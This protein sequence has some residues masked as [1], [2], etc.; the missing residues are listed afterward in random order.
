MFEVFPGDIEPFGGEDIVEL[1]RRLVYAEAQTSGVPLYNVAVP[2]QITLAD[3]GEDARVEWTGGEASTAYFPHRHVVFQSKATDT[4]PSLWKRETWTKASQRKGKTHILNEALT[5]AL[6]LGASYIGVTATGL[7]GAKPAERREAIREGIRE[8]GGNPDL[9]HSIHIYDGNALADWANRHHAVALWIKEQK[10]GL[11][12]SS[13]ATLNNWGRR[14]EMVSPPYVGGED[15]RF[16]IGSSDQDRLNFDR[17]AA[18]LVAHLQLADGHSARI[19]GPSGLGKSRS[20][21]E[22][23]QTGAAALKDSLLATAVFCDYREVS[24][25]LWDAVNTLADGGA[26]LILVVDECPREEAKKL[27][28][29]ARATG[30]RLRVVTLDTNS[31]SIDVDGCLAI[32]ALASNDQVIKGILASLLPKTTTR[33]EVA[34]IAD[35]CAGYPRIAVLAAQSY[36][37]DAPVFKSVEDVAQRILAGARITDRGQIRALECLSLFDGLAPDARPA[38]FDIVAQTLGLMTGDEMFE[39]LVAAT[40]HG[41]V[42]RYGDVFATQPQPIANYLGAKRLSYLRPS[43]VRAFLQTAPDEQRRSFLGRVR[44][45]CRSSTLRDVAVSMMTW[46]GELA[47]AEQLLTSRGSEFLAAFV[48][49]APDF[50]S[51]LI[52]RTFR[53]ASLADLARVSDDLGGLLDALERLAHRPDTFPAAARNL[54]R[55]SAA[56]A[57][58]GHGRATEITKQLFQLVL[59]GTA[60]PVGVRFA[61]LDEA[62]AEGGPAIHWACTRALD[63]ALET[64][65][66]YGTSGFEQLGDLPPIPDWRPG[67]AAEAIDFHREALGRLAAIRRLSPEAA[68]DAD[69]VVADHLRQLL[70][71]QLFEVVVAYLDEVRAALGFWPEAAKKIGDWLYFDRAQAEPVFAAKVRALYDT[72]LPIDIVDRAVFFSQFWPADIRD[73]DNSYEAGATERDYEF[74]GREAR[75]LAALIARDPVLLTRAIRSMATR[76]LH[77]PFAFADELAKHISTPEAVLGEALAALDQSGTKEGLS[78]VR[79]L[80]RALD[81]SFPEKAEALVQMAKQSE[82]LA[83]RELEI[84]A[85]VGLTEARVWEVADL[86]RSG[87]ASPFQV[88]PLSYGR[89]LDAMAVDVLRALIEA[90]HT[91]STDGGGWAAIEILSMYLYG[92]SSLSREEATLVKAAVLAPL[93]VDDVPDATMSGH[94]FGVLVKLLDLSGY[95]DAAFAGDFATLIVSACQ[96]TVSGSRGSLTDALRDGLVIV[97]RREPEPVWSALA[98]FYEVATRAERGRLYRLTSPQRNYSE[99]P[100]SASGGAG[101]LFDTPS[102]TTISWADLDPARRAPF[103]V[104]FTP[105]LESAQDGA[106]IWHP[107]LSVL[108]AKYGHLREFRSA[109]A[110]RIFPSSWSG[111]LS[112]YLEP[113][114]APL[115]TWNDNAVLGPWAAEVLVDLRRRIAGDRDR[116]R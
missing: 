49:V 74:S 86:V 96:S 58:R 111:A 104:S 10:A 32:D 11:A 94:A 17:F 24:G 85:S 50:V 81:A 52:T 16:A 13:F 77:S 63:G 45:L 72:T 26:P 53:D 103:L 68:A 93:E 112:E 51:G 107:A 66:F 87:R 29:R 46:D 88:V 76:T 59:S 23:M 71:P 90:L 28:E 22:A 75:K 102:M 36:E 109:L 54:F 6:S 38:E 33:D 60:A 2:L 27:H 1:L 110:A 82:T 42:G 89:A 99:R 15:E 43:V 12:L 91:R 41:V 31:Q 61:I 40:D 30:S 73:P 64:E 34:F 80:L 14:S 114:L 84:Y 98:A 115:E 47:S 100:S 5:R 67:T 44:H 48:H 37:R 8:A 69:R 21:Y 78:F 4:T 7:V 70:V 108:A 57:E 65:R 113:Y 35:L 106:M 105:L 97:I 3:G 9:L 92:R 101:I 116:A 20:V 39:H 55:L 83:G 25:K 62:L 19:T 79:P 95:V 56:N 18:R